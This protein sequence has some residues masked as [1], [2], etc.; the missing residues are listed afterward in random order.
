ML[1][2]AAGCVLGTFI[3]TDSTMVPAHYHGTVGGVTLSLMGLLL[4]FACRLRNCDPPPAARWLAWI[5]GSGLALMVAGLAWLALEGAPRKMPLG[6]AGSD[7]AGHLVA[8]S[9]TGLGGLLAI[10]GGVLFVWLA[11]RVLWNRRPAAI[12]PIC[13]LLARGVAAE[14]GRP[15]QRRRDLRP[16]AFLLAGGGVLVL[17]LALAYPPTPATLR[18]AVARAL[19]GFAPVDK[20]S[21]A[22]QKRRE[23]IEQRFAQAV[24]MLH[25]KEY[26]HAVAALHRVIE[27]APEMPEAH[28]NMGYALIGLGRFDAARDFFEGAI[29]L[30]RDQLNA[31]YGLAMAFEGLNDLPAAI[32]AMRTYAH[33]AAP[34]DPFRAK[35]EAAL[36]TWRE[37][38]ERRRA[39]DA[40]LPTH[41]EARK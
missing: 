34:D 29:A 4:H 19:S 8:S 31:Y 18:D 11:A 25:A 37:Q 24:V 38:I 30:R 6:D 32:G 7:S 23:E 41:P 17:G 39:A 15:A 36:W 20:S 33:L 40:P 1:L 9:L 3:R 12:D 5:Y 13:L 27:L 22:A 14:S 28:V 16:R 10:V 2:F 26:E 35:A 21:H